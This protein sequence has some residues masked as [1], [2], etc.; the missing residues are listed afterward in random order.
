MNA[1][2]IGAALD[3][4]QAEKQTKYY[5]A[6]CPNCRRTNKVALKQLRRYAPRDE[7]PASAKKQSIPADEK[8]AEAKSE[9]VPKEKKTSASKP[10]SKSSK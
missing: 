9:T 1:S 2:E 6:E 4:M 3:Q 7:S 5:M 8:K 10:K